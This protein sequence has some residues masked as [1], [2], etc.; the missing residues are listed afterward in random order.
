MCR[1]SPF[2]GLCAPPSSHSFQANSGQLHL[3]PSRHNDGPNQQLAVRSRAESTARSACQSVATTPSARPFARRLR[4]A[5]ARPHR[6]RQFE[7]CGASERAIYLRTR[8]FRPTSYGASELIIRGICD[9]EWAK[10]EGDN[11][12]GPFP[13]Q[14]NLKLLSSASGRKWMTGG[15][16]VG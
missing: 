16:S 3:H 15:Q 10:V 1:V 12:G 13:D 4:S 11:A 14:P 2:G 9:G 8:A 6:W 7:F 5:D